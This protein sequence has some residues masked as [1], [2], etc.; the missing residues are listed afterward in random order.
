MTDITRQQLEDLLRAAG[1][2]SGSVLFVHSSLSSLGNVSGGAET[3]VAALR[4]VLGRQGT[5]VVPTFTFAHEIET[6]FDPQREPSQMGAISETVRS[7]SASRRSRHLYHSVA[8]IGRLRDRI[9]DR[10]G[11]SAW[12]ADGPFWQLIALDAD[13]LLLGVP[14]TR[15][16]QFHVVEQIVN[17]AYRKW[18]HVDA[19]ICEPD[20]MTSPLPTRVYRPEPGFI[21]NDFNKF[22]RLLESRDVVGKSLIGNAITR[23]FKAQDVLDIGIAEYRDNQELFVKSHG[24]FTDLP[25]GTV[26]TANGTER[27]VIDPQNTYRKTLR[28]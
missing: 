8:A 9:T 7:L 18:L 28:D 3:V 16:T 1:V 11:P 27:W 10:H 13:I 15:C 22:G 26:I 5:L 4:E 12:A 24:V 19:V 21:G 2:R 20:G 17:V 6:V 23:L 14:Y 25:E